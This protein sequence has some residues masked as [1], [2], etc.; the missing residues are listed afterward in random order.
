M[1][2]SK[3]ESVEAIQWFGG[4]S[5]PMVTP[6]KVPYKGGVRICSFCG[7]P[8]ISHGLLRVPEGGDVRKYTLCPGDYIVT[9]ECGCTYGCSQ[10]VFETTYYGG[11]DEKVPIQPFEGSYID[12]R[13]TAN[14]KRL[15]AAKV[16]RVEELIASSTQE[17]VINAWAEA[18]RAAKA[19]ESIPTSRK[20][21]RCAI[22][23]VYNRTSR[24]TPLSIAQLCAMD[25]STIKKNPNGDWC[26]EMNGE[27]VAVFRPDE[28][29]VLDIYDV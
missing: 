10:E 11:Y 13:K 8:M 17:P 29:V 12:P 4:V 5:H 28:I 7:K 1:R 19:I 22:E 6:Y 2:Y 24:G 15:D 27:V 25:V 16:K 21:G 23:V 20:I 9:E 18:R 3:K 26:Q 14:N